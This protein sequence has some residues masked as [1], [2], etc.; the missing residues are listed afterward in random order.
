MIEYT[1]EYL[2][3]TR[4]YLCIW[5]DRNKRLVKREREGERKMDEWWP[6]K[7]DFRAWKQGKRIK[8]TFLPS[9]VNL[10]W[11]DDAGV[12]FSFSSIF[13]ASIRCSEKRMD[14][15]KMRMEMR[16]WKIL[17]GIWDEGTKECVR[18]KEEVVKKRL[19]D[20][21]QM[22]PLFSYLTIHF[23]AF[24]FLLHPFS[25]SHSL[26]PSSSWTIKERKREKERS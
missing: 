21:H 22:I 1:F 15:G 2:R 11:C 25:I 17:M 7:C 24:F 4:L 20:G 10:S 23:L 26:S 18:R 9:D 3:H 5:P 13:S 6:V 8:I 19:C 16:G 12:F 14:R